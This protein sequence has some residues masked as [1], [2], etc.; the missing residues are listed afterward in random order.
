MEYA[1]NEEGEQ[2]GEYAYLLLTSYLDGLQ[3][4]YVIL[5][6]EGGGRCRPD[7]SPREALENQEVLITTFYPVTSDATATVDGISTAITFP[8]N[9]PTDSL[10]ITLP[11]GIDFPVEF[12]PEYEK[13]NAQLVIN[14]SGRT[15]VGEVLI[16]QPEYF[17][18][19]P[20]F[21]TRYILPKSRNFGPNIITKGENGE[22]YIDLVNIYD[23]EHFMILPLTDFIPKS[24]SDCQDAVD[25]IVC[26]CNI[27]GL[28]PVIEE[29]GDEE[30]CIEINWEEGFNG[31]NM[32]EFGIESLYIDRGNSWSSG[33]YEG[34]FFS[35]S[36][37]LGQ[38]SL[39]DKFETDYRLDASGDATGEYV[40]LLLSSREYDSDGLQYVF[41]VI[42]PGNGGEACN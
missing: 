42:G 1:I 39:Y 6:G 31:C 11:S 9:P 32:D 15:Q 29:L 34:R 22:E 33:Y 13:Y 20:E 35:S 5:G 40:Y 17:E 25:P 26:Q 4:L 24:S 21:S 36:E 38:E 14:S 10:L 2:V 37:P 3:Y 8:T 16:V 28:G 12:E 30:F 18:G 27:N 7:I 41:L 19:F 23:D